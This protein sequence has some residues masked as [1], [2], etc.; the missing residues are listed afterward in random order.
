[1][2]IQNK[3]KVRIRDYTTIGYYGRP[4]TELSRDEL[5][6][7]FAELVEIYKECKDKNNRCKEVLGAEKFDAL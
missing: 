4:I 3:T 6:E 2:G 1:M 7:A 5:L